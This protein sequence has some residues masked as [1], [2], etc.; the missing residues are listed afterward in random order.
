VGVSAS[1]SWISVTSTSRLTAQRYSACARAPI[2]PRCPRR[3]FGAAERMRPATSQDHSGRV[4]SHSR[5]QG[6][7]PLGSTGKGKRFAEMRAAPPSQE[8]PIVPRNSRGVQHLASVSLTVT[9][10]SHCLHTRARWPH[11]TTHTSRVRSP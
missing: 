3:G 10:R 9:Q 6:S 8:A 11:R 2:V 5:G 1:I 4:S 7:I